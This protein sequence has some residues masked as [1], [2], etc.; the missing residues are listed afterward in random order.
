MKGSFPTASIPL[1]YAEGEA[2]IIIYGMQATAY[3]V[4]SCLVLSEPSFHS[5][6]R[7]RPVKC[8]QHLRGTFL[9][10]SRTETQSSNQCQVGG[11]D[12]RFLDT[13][14]DRDSLPLLP[15]CRQDR[16]VR[17]RC[18]PR[19]LLRWSNMESIGDGV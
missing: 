7:I 17:L 5:G 14:A 15:A 8:T 19:Q 4:R 18:N 2:S 9:S 10:R 11:W 1:G 16:A 3:S 6:T 13:Y 12:G